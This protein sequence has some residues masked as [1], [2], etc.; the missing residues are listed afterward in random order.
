[1]G[2][3][4]EISRMNADLVIIRDNF[5]QFSTKSYVVTPHLNR[6]DETVQNEG[7][8]H[9]VSMTNK[10]NYPSNII[11]YPLLSGALLNQR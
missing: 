9:M 3:S 2:P 6:L 10:Q 8:Q 11:K 1:M 4:F 7:S 5:Y